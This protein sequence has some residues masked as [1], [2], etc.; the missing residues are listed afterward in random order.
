MRRRPQ[1]LVELRHQDEL[2]DEPRAE[3]GAGLL[4]RQPLARPPRSR[5]PISFTPPDG[6]F[7]NGDRVLVNTDDGAATGSGGGPDNDH[8]DNAY[9]DTPPDGTS[10][11]MAMFL[12]FND[13]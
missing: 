11:T 6:N 12:F 13:T 2:A 3:R 7:D 4:L 10:P 1:V 9:M 5:A 8:L